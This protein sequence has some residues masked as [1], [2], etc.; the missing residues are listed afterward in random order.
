MDVAGE[1]EAR[2]RVRGGVG[3]GAV[4]GARDVDLGQ[5]ARAGEG[6]WVGAG[7]RV[8]ADVVIGRGGRVGPDAVVRDTA[9][10]RRR[11]G[12]GHSEFRAAA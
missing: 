9:V 12:S 1:G 2:W 10:V 5:R 6:T 7:A 11:A 8:G 4:V 3:G